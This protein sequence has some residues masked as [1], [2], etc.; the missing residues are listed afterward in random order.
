M[1]R[2]AGI[3]F[4]RLYADADPFGYRTRWYEQRKRNLMMAALPRE[5]FARG[6]ELGCS[7]G[8]LT[9]ALGE[10]CDALLGT[11]ISAQA[12][13]LARLRVG[14]VS[15]VVLE[16]ATHPAVWPSGQFDLIVFSE[17][18]YYFEPG[19]F[20]QTVAA[21]RGSL[22]VDGCLLACHWRHPFEGAQRSAEE[23]HLAL[24]HSLALPSACRYDDSDFILQVWAPDPSVA[25]Q[26]GLR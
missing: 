5:R 1:S 23:V 3:D 10:R 2:P 20:E 25:Q 22:A 14:P 18:G 15:R 16:Q 21:L 24:Q 13:A 17:V 4:N 8:E 6:W 12:I 26:E 19:A 11:D 7:N 9:A